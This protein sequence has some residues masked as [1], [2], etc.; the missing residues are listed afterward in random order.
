[1]GEELEDIFAGFRGDTGAMRREIIALKT[2]M[3]GPLVDEAERAGRAIERALL[4]GVAQGKFGF[5]DLKRVALSA[6]ADIARGALQ[7]GLGAIWGS[8]GGGAGSG[9]GGGGGTSLLGAAQGLALALLGAP[10]RATGGPV[11]NSRPYWVGERGPELFVPTS[12][13]RVEAAGVA[14]GTNARPLSITVN[15]Q[16]AAGQDPQRLA[17]SGRQLARAVR[18]AVMQGEG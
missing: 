10:G 9:G 13:G 3:G 7:S 11:V 17:Q 16:G 8:D 15:V 1:M 4:R 14:G 12:S 18:R 2:E 6:M 5:E